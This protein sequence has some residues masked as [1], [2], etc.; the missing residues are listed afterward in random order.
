MSRIILKISGEA[1][2]NNEE[3]VNKEKLELVLNTIKLLRSKGHLVAII[4]GGGNIFRGRSNPNMDPAN[5]TAIGVSGS[6][7]NS[8]Y[9]K[10]YLEQNGNKVALSTPFELNSLIEKYSDTELLDK[11]NNGEII[12]FG[13]GVGKIG[14]ST[15]SGIILANDKLQCDLLIKMTNVDGVYNDDP[16]KNPNAIKYDFITFEKVL[17]DGLK[18]MDEQAILECKNK[19]IKILVI[20][21]YKY[22]ELEDFFEGRKV[23]TLIGE[24]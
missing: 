15:D 10:D 9:L 23:G 8:L 20:D 17:E 3:L 16:N 22:I 5:S 12:I 24:K 2:S 13:G 21:F 19:N 11:Y 6:I 14:Y 7:I 18:I 4:I 1:L